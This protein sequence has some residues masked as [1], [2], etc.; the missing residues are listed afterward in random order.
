MRVLQALGAETSVSKGN[1]QTR[2]VKRATE[3][4]R[5]SGGKK[6][7]PARK[8]PHFILQVEFNI[9]PKLV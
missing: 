1:V 9:L 3:N 5:G 2:L 7:E 4:A 8:N 6:G